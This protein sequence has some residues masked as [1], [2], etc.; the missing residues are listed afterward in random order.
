MEQPASHLATITLTGI[1][2]ISG[3]KR[4]LLKVEF[5][6]KPPEPPKHQSYMLA[7]GKHDGPIGVLAINENTAQVKVD[8][9]GTIMEITFEKPTST[10]PK[11]EPPTQASI[12]AKWARTPRLPAGF[13]GTGGRSGF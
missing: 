4:A 9:C 11:P 12:R 5:P 13:S 10:P 6:S 1:T 3:A 8:N 2:T 7:E